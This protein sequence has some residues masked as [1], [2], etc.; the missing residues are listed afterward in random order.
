MIVATHKIFDHNILPKGYVPILVGAFN[1]SINHTYLRDDL[2]DNISEKNANYCE[3][4]GLY[5]I[6]KNDKSST[7]IGLSHYRRFFL[8][9]SKFNITSD[10]NSIAS[11]EYIQDLLKK[12]DII[13][14]KKRH[15]PFINNRQHFVQ[16]HYEKDINTLEYVISQY[17]SD[18]HDDFKKVMSSNSL[19]LYN[20][21]IM[22]RNCFD[23][24]CQ[25]LFD[26]LFKVEGLSDISGYDSYQSRLYGFLSERLLNVWVLHHSLNKKE[27]SVYEPD[28][29]RYV[30]KGKKFL[31]DFIRSKKRA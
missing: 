26:I 9:E 10:Y 25:W 29:K 4:T 30:E 15:Y 17:Y 24:Y 22:N 3:L 16:S 14:P 1:K 5:W 2:S 21:F 8:K 7:W 31:Q 6:W 19:H 23:R 28:G 12:F 13:L 11:E 18:Y 27:L 20:M